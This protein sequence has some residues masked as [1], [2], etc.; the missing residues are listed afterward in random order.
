MY[1]FRTAGS[2]LKREVSIQVSCIERFHSTVTLYS[3]VNS[4]TAAVR[5][6]CT[7]HY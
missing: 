3:I 2:A 5:D 4:A 7:P 6:E 1:I